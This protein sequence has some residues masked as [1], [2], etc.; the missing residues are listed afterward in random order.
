MAE[1]D[2][3]DD[4]EDCSTIKNTC[5]GSMASVY[6]IGCC[7]CSFVFP[8]LQIV[9]SYLLYDIF[10]KEYNFKHD[11][12]LINDDCDDEYIQFEE[13]YQDGEDEEYISIVKMIQEMETYGYIACACT[14]AGIT[15][16]VL[17]YLYYKSEEDKSKKLEIISS[18]SA[19]IGVVASLGLLVCMYVNV[20][21][22]RRFN[23]LHNKVNEYCHE[24]SDIFIKV[25]DI[26]DWYDGPRDVFI[27]LGPLVA[28]VGL[29]A[30]LAIRCA[31]KNE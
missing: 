16:I 13:L 7:Y 25:D 31:I 20:N 23:T 15:S 8:I 2:S 26:N 11:E 10:I 6:G 12:T 18:I 1:S 19:F 21:F 4:T 3:D 5:L 24:T 28:G 17:F 30:F 27:T 9:C 22:A 29:I 14:I